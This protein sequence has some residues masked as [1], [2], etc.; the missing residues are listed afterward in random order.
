MVHELDT[1]A[2]T[3]L[4]RCLCRTMWDYERDTILDDAQFMHVIEYYFF[5]L[6]K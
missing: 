5:L 4:Q 2:M 1:W 3:P 6:S